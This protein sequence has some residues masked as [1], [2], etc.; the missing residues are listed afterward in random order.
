MCK[1]VATVNVSMLSIRPRD[2][3]LSDKT[4]KPNSTSKPA[5]SQHTVACHGANLSIGYLG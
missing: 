2:E 1:P 4:Y 3:G 5:A